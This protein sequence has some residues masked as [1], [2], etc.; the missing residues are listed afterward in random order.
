MAEL[1]H[2]LGQAACQAVQMPAPLGEPALG[3]MDQPLGQPV[4][5]A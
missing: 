2:G 3:A 4:E 5:R 1:G